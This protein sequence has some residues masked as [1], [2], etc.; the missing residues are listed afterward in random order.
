MSE[1]R[2]NTAPWTRRTILIAACIVGS[3]ALAENISK[4]FELGPG[5][6]QATSVMRSYPI[7]NGLA[8][9]AVVKYR[10]ITGGKDGVSIAIEL[11]EP[12]TA[13]G[14]E[15]PIVATRFVIATTEEKTVI[16][17]SLAS[18]RGCSQP[19][20]IRV[21]HSGTGPMPAAV[22][23]T[24]RMDYDGQSR[25]IN[26]SG[27]GFIGK[28]GSREI[29]I[30]GSDGFNQGQMGITANWNHMI[31]PIPGPEAVKFRLQLGFLINNNPHDTML[32]TLAEAYSSNES[33]SGLPKFRILEK[34]RE[35]S[36][37]QWKLFV[38]NISGHDAFMNAP[39]VNF[40][41]IC[42]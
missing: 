28:G 25:S 33:R 19:W 26:V 42:P 1:E 39:T 14:V 12:D 23:G 41:P 37:G 20:R 38:S 27:P 13:P 30:G 7:P 29:D 34:I 17:Q 18:N 8:V 3:E 2:P 15:G 35:D 5:T 21:K 10:R 31:G 36:P 22:F 16:I 32:L 11:R 4:T 24:A 9:A 6:P 40:A